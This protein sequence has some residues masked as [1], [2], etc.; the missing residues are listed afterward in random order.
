MKIE[1]YLSEI[2]AWLLFDI[3]DYINLIFKQ[4]DQ[5]IKKIKSLNHLPIKIILDN[6]EITKEKLLP[7]NLISGN[8]V[9]VFLQQELSLIGN[10][11]KK[12]KISLISNENNRRPYDIWARAKI[13][14]YDSINNILFL[15]YNEQLI[16][17]EDMNKI[18]PLS[19]QKKLKEDIGIFHIKKISNS[20]YEKFKSE[21]EKFKSEIEEEKQCFLYHNFNSIKS[22]LLFILPKRNFK[23]LLS[24]K[25]L[26][27]K[28]SNNE[29]TNTNSGF[30]SRSGKSEESDKIKNFRK[31][32]DEEDDIL[33]QINKYKYTK[34]FVYKSYFKKDAEKILKTL[35]IK[36][37]YYISLIDSEEFK[38][39]I[40]GNDENDFNEEKNILEKEYKAYEL[41]VDININKTELTD[42]AGKIKI[43]YIYF[44]K[45]IVYLIGEDKY[46]SSFKAFIS[47]K[48]MYSKEI[49][50]SCKE[51]ENIEK[52]LTN[53]KK[54]YK[55]K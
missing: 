38:I 51:K 21:Y 18:R 10:T 14:S 49:Q 30:S 47:M 54:E 25:E 55:I 22:S 43:K 6:E 24:I 16:L 40:Y 41:K 5:K 39:I 12:G 34:T 50:K 4:E 52:K 44:G 1:Y 48:M 33:N 8:Y 26:E 35:I 9:E 2:Y 3:E 37:K 28:Y 20:E 19:E 17:I 45:K 42:F 29:E 13:V 11:Q 36:N 23:N 27:E 32:Y 7:E 15:E 46:I 31:I 53:I